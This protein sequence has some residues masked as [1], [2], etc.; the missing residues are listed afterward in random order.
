MLN[1]F[2][3][4]NPFLLTILSLWLVLEFLLLCSVLNCRIL[5]SLSLA[6]A[7][8]TVLSSQLCWFPVA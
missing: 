4:T 6:A 5:Y 3:R 2:L 7:S 1:S 8:G